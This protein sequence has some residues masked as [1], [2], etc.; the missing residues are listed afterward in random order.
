MAPVQH[1]PAWKRIGLNLKKQSSG[2]A[3]S[4]D[5]AVQSSQDGSNKKR[6]RETY[7]DNLPNHVSN[8]SGTWSSVKKQKRSAR[9]EDAL[10]TNGS[11]VIAPRFSSRPPEDRRSLPRKS[12]SFASDTKQDDG[13][14]TKELLDTWEREQKS[15]QERSDPI[16]TNGRATTRQPPDGNVTLN[17]KPP[18]NPKKPSAS[19]NRKTTEKST[20]TT[21][22]V[23]AF[24]EYLSTFH[25]FRDRWKFNKTK[26]TNLLRHLF[27]L[28]V[29]PSE[30]NEALKDYLEG[31]K[32]DSIKSYLRERASKV[33]DE[34][35]AIFTSESTGKSVDVKDPGDATS[36]PAQKSKAMDSRQLPGVSPAQRKQEYREA[37]RKFKRELKEGLVRHEEWDVMKDPK[38]RSWLDRRFRAETVLWCVGEVEKRGED[39]DRM[40]V[41]DGRNGIKIRPGI[42]ENTSREHAVGR[43]KGAGNEA[44]GTAPKRKRKRKRRTGLPDD[45]SSSESSESSDDSEDDGLEKKRQNLLDRLENGKAKPTKK[46]SQVVGMESES[47][48]ESESTSESAS[49]SESDSGVTTSGSDERTSSGE[50]NEDSTSG[51]DANSE[52]SGSVENT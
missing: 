7:E 42:V 25:N 10:S 26:Q 45:D 47:E 5:Y 24:L 1:V 40:F 8:T 52:T 18:R 46:V 29:I 35:E 6:P 16:S 3:A 4:A 39:A 9:D 17:P 31:L 13:V 20:A 21:E 2:S 37:V 27:D 15:G 11:A 23:S 33:A 30:Q 22:S 43:A 50:G 38:W 51:S 34:E 44:N 19:V 14:S 36:D 28:S 41:G 48:S 12:V 32:G 49:E